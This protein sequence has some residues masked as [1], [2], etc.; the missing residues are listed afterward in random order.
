MPD[1]S[2]SVNSFKQIGIAMHDFHGDFDRFPNGGT[3]WW[4][5]IDYGN[6]QFGTN[7]TTPGTPSQPPN[8]TVGMFYQILPYIEQDQLWKTFSNDAWNNAGP[9]SRTIL[10][11]YVC[12]SRRAPMRNS[13]NRGTIDYAWIIPGANWPGYPS[14][15]TY[16][17]SDYWNGPGDWGEPR[18]DH[19]G[20]VCRCCTWS[21]PSGNHAGPMAELKIT[22][23]SITDG[24]S[25]TIAVSEK[26]MFPPKYL[27]GTGSD[28]QGWCCGWDEDVTRI[29]AAPPKRDFI[30]INGDEW[31]GNDPRAWGQDNWAQAGLCVGSAHPG[32]VNAL[33]G[34]GS[35]RNVPY[36]VDPLVFWRLGG[37]ADGVPVSTDF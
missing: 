4:F 17:N 33:F 2:R 8:Q 22:F 26:W 29:T 7:F 24:S 23:A 18:Y 3:D 25:N 27:I 35:V 15:P 13:S 5:G 10:P 21:D 1:K 14:P 34:D 11:I 12:P 28:D 30:L 31:G 36:D 9:V 6:G 37:R 16:P 19:G 32:G 20:I